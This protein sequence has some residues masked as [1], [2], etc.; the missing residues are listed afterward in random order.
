MYFFGVGECSVG[1]TPDYNS[2]YAMLSNRYGHHSAV[3]ATGSGVSPGSGGS[4]GGGGEGEINSSATDQLH[5]PHLQNN[6][7][8][9]AGSSVVNS[10]G[11]VSSGQLFHAHTIGHFTTPSATYIPGLA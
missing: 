7:N 3:V 4:G 11:P 5:Y 9:S 6:G 1:N 10:G 8:G 2:D